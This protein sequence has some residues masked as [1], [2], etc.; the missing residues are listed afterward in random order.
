MTNMNKVS[1]NNKQLETLETI[2]SFSIMLDLDPSWTSAIALTE[3]SLGLNQQSR[4]GCKGVFQMSSIAM[5]DLLMEMLKVDD[6]LIDI[7]CG[8]LFLRLLLRRHKTLKGATD[9]FCDPGDLH[10]YYNKVIK[11]MDLLK[12]YL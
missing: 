10:F 1:L 8:L 12:G 7:L 4:T 6:D 5:K 9:H 2:R 11:N 3:S